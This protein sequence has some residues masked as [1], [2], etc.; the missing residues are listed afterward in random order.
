MQLVL[1]RA[2][3]TTTSSLRMTCNLIAPLHG[4][5]SGEDEVSCVHTYLSRKERGV[6]HTCRYELYFCVDEGQLSNDGFCAERVP[7]LPSFRSAPQQD[8]NFEVI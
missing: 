6:D 2:K 4:C 5:N 8:D 3:C 7:Q 1:C